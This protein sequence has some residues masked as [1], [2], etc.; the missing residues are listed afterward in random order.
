M[1]V[2]SEKFE[3]NKIELLICRFYMCCF[4]DL[5]LLH[6]QLAIV[7]TIGYGFPVSIKIVVYSK[8]AII[9]LCIEIA[10]FFFH[11]PFY[12]YY[13]WMF[14]RKCVFFI[15]WSEVKWNVYISNCNIIFPF[16]QNEKKRKNRIKTENKNPECLDFQFSSTRNP[17]YAFYT[18][19]KKAVFMVIFRS[20]LSSLQFTMC[21][22][23][24]ENYNYNQTRACNAGESRNE[25]KCPW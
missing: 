4:A 2:Y 19:K 12:Y 17:M 13:F 1:H 3:N 10:S 20:F 9:V 24:E 14:K 7:A 23:V 16:G 6:W 25:E 15:G 18:V 22:F 21:E 8:I 5:Y 11:I